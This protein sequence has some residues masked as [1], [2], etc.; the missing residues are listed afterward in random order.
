VFWLK[1]EYQSL[2]NCILVTNVPAYLKNIN[3]MKDLLGYSLTWAN[4]ELPASAGTTHLNW[5]IVSLAGIYMILLTA[6]YA[7]LY[8]IRRLPFPIGYGEEPPVLDQRHVGLGGWLVLPAFGLFARPIRVLFF[9]GSNWTVYSS[10]SWHSLTDPSGGAYH[11]LW[12]PLLI[13]ELLVNLTLMSFPV[14]LI[15]LFF[16]RRRTFPPLFVMYLLFAVITITL[17]HFELQMIPAVVGQNSSSVSRE[18]AQS[19]IACAIWI[20][21]MLVSKRVKATFVR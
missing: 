21:Y 7:I 15:I 9:M 2:T 11:G 17:D 13:F 18:L 14:F 3:Q 4:E 6:G 10:E 20:P 19:Y 1:Y 8:R 16:Q 5:T 12:A